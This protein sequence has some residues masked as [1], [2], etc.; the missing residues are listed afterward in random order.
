MIYLRVQSI[1]D[2]RITI[3]PILYN[4]CYRVWKKLQKTNLFQ[5]FD[6]ELSKKITNSSSDQLVSHQRT[7]IL[8]KILM[9]IL[10]FIKYSVLGIVY[11][12]KRNK[13]CFGSSFAVLRFNILL[14]GLNKLKRFIFHHMWSSNLYHLLPELCM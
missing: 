9:L 14:V 2:L 7:G 12:F 6:F 1:Q 11:G 4:K 10:M 8:Y 5:T 13:N 3:K